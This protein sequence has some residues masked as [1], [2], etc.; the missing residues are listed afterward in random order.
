LRQQP[1]NSGIDVSNFNFNLDT[2]D[3][4]ICIALRTRAS[5]VRNLPRTAVHRPTTDMG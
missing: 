2:L 1:V 4:Q 5:S 3:G